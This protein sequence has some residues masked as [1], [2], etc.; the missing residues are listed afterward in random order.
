MLKLGNLRFIGRRGLADRTHTCSA[1]GSYY[2]YFRHMEIVWHCRSE[3]C[4][5]ESYLIIARGT[6][7]DFVHARWT[8]Y[9]LAIKVLITK[10]VW[11]LWT[12][13]CFVFLGREECWI[14]LIEFAGYYKKVAGA[15][16]L[17]IAITR[18][19]VMFGVA[20]SR[21]FRGR[22]CYFKCIKLDVEVMP[23]V[24]AFPYLRVHQ[25]LWLWW[26]VRSILVV[27]CL[28]VGFG[29]CHGCRLLKEPCN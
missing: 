7:A 2:V 13:Q 22:D 25:Q 14:C 8:L 1:K 15:Q 3:N 23:Y 11:L 12:A 19:V 4:L 17:I 21:I 24:I 6:A 18:V 10:C 20:G 9:I 28:L 5:S 27:C 26:E 29:C 16:D